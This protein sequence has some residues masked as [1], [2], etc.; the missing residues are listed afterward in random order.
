MRTHDILNLFQKYCDQYGV[1]DIFSGYSFYQADKTDSRIISRNPIEIDIRSA[2]PTFLNFLL[3]TD[4]P[5]LQKINNITDKI[6]RNK[7]LSITLKRDE[8]YKLKGVDLELMNKLA[9]AIIVCCVYSRYENVNIL[10]F[11]K[12][13]LLFLGQQKIIGDRDS[14]DF[15]KFVT[16]NNINFRETIYKF[17]IRFNNN[18][19]FINNELGVE[20]KGNYFFRC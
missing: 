17:Y 1:T 20:I 11:K 6:E 16:D 9:R 5:L 3:P 12:D 18:S 8:N 7:T 10:E 2:F 15:F 19:Y 13:S 4:D 14:I